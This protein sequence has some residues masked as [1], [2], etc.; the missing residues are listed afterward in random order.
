MNHDSFERPGSNE[1]SLDAQAPDLC[2]CAFATTATVAMQRMG[3]RMKVSRFTV[4][5]AMGCG[6]VL[7]NCGGPKPAESPEGKLTASVTED[8]FETDQSDEG[9]DDA[10]EPLVESG[11]SFEGISALGTP[12]VGGEAARP[13]PKDADATE[14]TEVVHEQDEPGAGECRDS[15]AGL[16]IGV[17]RKS[18]NLKKGSLVAQMD[19]HI[20]NL[21]LR[22][23]RTGGLPTVVKRFRYT[24]PK[25]KL[26]WTPIPRDEIARIEVRVESDDGAYESAILIPWSVTI[27]HDEVVF[28]TNK[29]VVRQ[30]EVPSLEDSL[31]KIKEVLTEGEE[32]GL[33]GITLFIAGHTDTRGTSGHNMTLSRNRAQA[34]AHWFMQAGLCTPIA[35]QGFGEMALKKVTADEVDEQQNRRVDYILSVEPPVIREGAPAAWQWIT[36]G[37]ARP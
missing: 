17:N 5:L 7:A 32:Y 19:G 27:D 28:D 16:A 4:V 2:L 36:Q 15:T 13:A 25:R 20:C 10:E 12:R 23:Q 3:S 22:I 8:P 18:V 9:D 6:W 33:T 31:E 35:F 1:A 14:D 30:S 21:S 24:G 26:Q 29:A 11:S 37:C 34:I